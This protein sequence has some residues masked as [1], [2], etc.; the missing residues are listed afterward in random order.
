[1]ENSSIN[2]QPPIQPNPPMQ[3]NPQPPIQPSPQPILQTQPNTRPYETSM[4]S[5]NLDS[6]KTTK[7]NVFSICFA[8]F[9]GI[10]LIISTISLFTKG[11]WSFS[12]PF[13]TSIL[14][15]NMYDARSMYFSLAISAVFFGVISI[16]TAKKSTSDQESVQRTWKTA[17]ILFLIFGIIY[18]VNMVSLAIYALMGVGD[19]SGL[20]HEELWLNSVLPSFIIAAINFGISVIANLISKG[21]AFL[22][23]IMSI[24]TTSIAGIALILIIIYIFTNFYG[25]SSSYYDYSDY[26]DKYLY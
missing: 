7:I 21:K 5:I 13:P 14:T 12:F 26:L 18:A 20:D 22:I 16:I 6:E 24:V 4:K 11:K 10:M 23:K 8:L 3:P 1:M 17:S 25:K 9:F 19:K 15:T 2:P